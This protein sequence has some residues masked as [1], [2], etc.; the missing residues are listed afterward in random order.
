MNQAIDEKNR[1]TSD[2]HVGYLKLTNEGNKSFIKS[3]LVVPVMDTP[4]RCRN[5]H[6]DI[7][8]TRRPKVEIFNYSGNI[9][10]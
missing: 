7:V 5:L 10:L 4:A 3:L 1:D 9:T 8:K 6:Q 2:N